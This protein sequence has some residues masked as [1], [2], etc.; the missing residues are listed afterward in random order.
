ML[1][2]PAETR[3]GILS[4]MSL[5]S[6]NENRNFSKIYIFVLNHTLLKYIWFFWN[7]FI[8]STGEVELIRIIFPRVQTNLSESRSV[9]FQKS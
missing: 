1:E 3:V 6:L 8:R 2:V 4:Y 9:I 5:S 7:R